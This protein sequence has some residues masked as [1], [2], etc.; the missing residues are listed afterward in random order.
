MGGPDDHRCIQL[1][2]PRTLDER[3]ADYQHSAWRRA[4]IAA[5]AFAVAIGHLAAAQHPGSYTPAD[6]ENGAR[7]FGQQKGEFRRGSSDEDLMR[8]IS[9]GVNPELTCVGYVRARTGER[10]G[11]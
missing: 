4:A 3:H 2:N 5:A 11:P 10:G 7:L 9:K 6:V 1:P 8:T